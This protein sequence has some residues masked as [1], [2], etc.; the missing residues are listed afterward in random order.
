MLTCIQ[1]SGVHRELG[2]RFSRMQSLTLDLLGPSELLV[3]AGA[4]DRG[5]S[6]RGLIGG[7]AWAD[8]LSQSL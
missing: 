7:G 2:V 4:G 6:G 8:W 5:D 3:S 1:C